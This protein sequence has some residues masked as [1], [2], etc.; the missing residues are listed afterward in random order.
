MEREGLLKEGDKVEMEESV[1][2][3]LTGNLYYY[4]IKDAVAMSDN[5]PEK[6]KDKDGY[7]TGIVES[8]TEDEGL[9][10]VKVSYEE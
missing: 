4:T 1:L 5:M 6:L 9:Y 8:I 2:K 3:T 10:F 7:F